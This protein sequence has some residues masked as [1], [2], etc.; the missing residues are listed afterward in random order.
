MLFWNLS[1]L[2]YSLTVWCEYEES[3]GVV[4]ENVSLDVKGL[5]STANVKCKSVCFVIPHKL[6]LSAN[7]HS[8]YGNP[9]SPYCT[10]SMRCCYP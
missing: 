5:Y 1:L 2:F 9:P 4:C 10:K 8:L 7:V 6:G 3:E